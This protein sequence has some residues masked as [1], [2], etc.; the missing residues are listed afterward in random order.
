MS[1]VSLLLSVSDFGA[2][3]NPNIAKT[4]KTVTNNPG[5]V[6]SYLSTNA[7]AIAGLNPPKIPVLKLYANDTEVSRTEGGNDATIHGNIAPVQRAKRIPKNAW[8]DAA[9]K[10]SPFPTKCN[11]TGNDQAKLTALKYMRLT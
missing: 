4:A 6:L 1:P 10:G 8:L 3:Y 11:N 2:I 9:T 7:V 5:A